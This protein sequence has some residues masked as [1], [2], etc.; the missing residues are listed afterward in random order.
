[1][2]NTLGI[3]VSNVELFIAVEFILFAGSV[4][5]P[6]IVVVF[7]PLSYAIFVVLPCKVKRLLFAF[8]NPD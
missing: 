7:V 1:M 3:V 5:N 8:V 4:N 6:V 2:F